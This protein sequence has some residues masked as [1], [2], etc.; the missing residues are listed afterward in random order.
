MRIYNYFD[1]FFNVIF[2]IEIT[3]KIISKGLFFNGIHS[4]LRVSW[5]VL[6]YLFIDIFYIYYIEQ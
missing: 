5:N 3:M 6:G 4:Y 2:V 1:D